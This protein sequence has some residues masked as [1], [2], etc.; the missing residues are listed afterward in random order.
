MP[1]LHA[2]GRA[3]VKSGNRGAGRFAN[4]RY[5]TDAPCGAVKLMGPD[6]LIGCV[7]GPKV[8]PFIWGQHSTSS[9]DCSPHC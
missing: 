6:W 9:S 3:R 2:R 1:V 8:V 4:A 5:R 7:V